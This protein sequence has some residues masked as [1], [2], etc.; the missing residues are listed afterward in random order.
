M[1]KYPSELAARFIVRLPEAWRAAIKDEAKKQHR[2]MNAEILAAIEDA[3][4][5]KG[6]NLIERP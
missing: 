1:T 3:M 2:S 4:S 6:V 5:R